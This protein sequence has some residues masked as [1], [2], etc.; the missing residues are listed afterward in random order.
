VRY[1]VYGLRRAD[2]RSEGSMVWAFES[3]RVRE[4]DGSRVILPIT[5]NQLL[6]T[7]LALSPEPR[8]PCTLYHVP[9][10]LLR[11]LSRKAKLRKP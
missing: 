3:S 2:P 5:D 6:I 10:P 8:A 1:A 9:F 7:S 11:S 4:F